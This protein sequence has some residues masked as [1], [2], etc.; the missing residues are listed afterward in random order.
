MSGVK[1]KAINNEYLCPSVDLIAQFIKA[2]RWTTHVKATL[3]LISGNCDERN[4]L[5][6]TTE[7]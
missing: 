4:V 3:S 1:P 7:F 6:C 2:L 5:K